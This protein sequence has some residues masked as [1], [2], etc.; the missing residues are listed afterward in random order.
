MAKKKKEINYRRSADLQTDTGT[1]EKKTR[2]YEEEEPI[3][4]VFRKKKRKKLE[5][6]NTTYTPLRCCFARRFLFAAEPNQKF[7]ILKNKKSQNFKK[8]KTRFLSPLHS[9]AS[10]ALLFSIIF[11]SKDNPCLHRHEK[12]HT[13]EKEKREVQFQTTKKKGHRPLPFSCNN[14]GAA[15]STKATER[16]A[17]AAAAV[18]QNNMMSTG[19][20]LSRKRNRC[21]RN[22]YER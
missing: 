8:K 2:G 6:N 16:T 5:R 11:K 22:V 19:K 17:A 4:Q 3:C 7:K 12:S 20:L 14:R 15:N 10:P 9:F 1:K 13:R 18:V 21:S